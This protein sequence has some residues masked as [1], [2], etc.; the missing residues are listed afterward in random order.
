MYKHFDNCFDKEKYIPSFPL[1]LAD[2]IKNFKFMGKNTVTLNDIRFK[3]MQVF[4]QRGCLAFFKYL[5]HKVF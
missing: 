2:T 1:C 5:E 3:H 4:I